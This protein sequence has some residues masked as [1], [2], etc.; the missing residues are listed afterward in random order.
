MSDLGRTSDRSARWRVL[1]RQVPDLPAPFPVSAGKALV[2]G[3]AEDCDVILG[4]DRH[5]DV[6]AHHARVS[7]E[8][9]QL[10]IEDLG[11]T[12]GVFVDG[13]RVEGKR[14]LEHGQT[15]QLGADGP[16]F[17]ALSAARLDETVAVR[18][19]ELVAASRMSSIG[20]DT[21]RLVRA[22]L[23]LPGSV[24]VEE[25]VDRSAG[26]NSRRITILASAL[27]VTVLGAGWFLYQRGRA[28]R[29]AL[30]AVELENTRLREQ[31]EE[32]RAAIDLQRND[33]E[34]RR[35]E[36]ERVQLAW[37]AEKL[38]LEDEARLLRQSIAAIEANEANARGEVGLLRARLDETN[39]TLASYNPVRL[40]SE[41]L[42]GVAR[43]ESA[44]VMIEASQVFREKGS[45]RLLYVDRNAG[46]GAD[47]NLEGRGELFA[48]EATGSGFSISPDGWIVTNAHVVH[49]KEEARPLVLGG[50]E[51]RP[52]VVVRVVFSGTNER[53]DARLV[54][55][56]ADG[57]DDLAL[58]DIEPFEGMPWIEPPDPTVAPPP[59]GS[60]VYLIGFPLGKRVLHE[61]DR[62]LASTFQGVLSRVLDDYL[63]VDASVHPGASGG[64]LIDVR[65]EVLGVVVGMQSIDEHATAS[66][67]GYILPASK[68]A[69][70]WPPPGADVAAGESD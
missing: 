40:L 2:L 46:P 23:G 68:L 57:R 36:G 29:Q 8:G 49:K 18:R 31:L 38:A 30:A 9:D 16:R 7:I 15:F 44:T 60:E 34:A 42:E 20:D 3:R 5:P 51:L 24:G 55:W 10:T 59:R 22:R 45:N 69:L 12:N 61:D 14:T 32:H 63:Q 4:G 17:V 39:E 19:P 66:Q 1:A 41:R 13:E 53:H 70:I 64:P 67:I 26:R 52:D 62:L 47:L 37:E 21:M 28:E 6:S 56:V 58:L 27:A 54:T 50:L 43:V 65:G 48:L 11:S 33:W 35:L 25:L